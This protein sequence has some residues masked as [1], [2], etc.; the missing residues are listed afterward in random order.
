MIVQPSRGAATRTAPCE[1]MTR[2]RLGS[3]R[4]ESRW[5]HTD[6]KEKII[7]IEILKWERVRSCTGFYLRFV[8]DY[9]QLYRLLFMDPIDPALPDIYEMQAGNE[10]APFRFVV[11][12]IREAMA[13]G[14]LGDGDP[15]RV[16]LS[17]WAHLHGLCALADLYE[18]LKRRSNGA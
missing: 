6:D 8:T 18:G 3:I 4:S 17:V 14:H 12:R 15:G 1:R 16:G 11:D 5:V 2:G 9:P 10:A 13:D 7:S